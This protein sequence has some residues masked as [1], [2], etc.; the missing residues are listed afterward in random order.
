MKI[1]KIFVLLSTLAIALTSCQV[2]Q[3]IEF[4]V[5]V[6]S[7][8]INIGP[9]GGLRTISVKSP[10]NW[11]A[12]TQAPWI[13][14]S[15]ANGKSS[16]ECRIIIDS[17][18]YDT[19]REAWVTF[20]LLGKTNELKEFQVIQE[21]YP[22]SITLKETEVKIPEYA[23]Y[24]ERSFDVAVNSNVDFDVVIP[25]N[26]S[27]IMSKKENPDFDRGIRPRNVMVHFDWKV[28]T[29]PNKNEVEIVFRPK[30]DKQLARQDNLKV[31]QGAAQEIEAGTVKGDSLAL[32]AIARAINMWREW[33]TAD[34]MALWDGI[35]VWK[36]GKDKG[37][38]K[39]AHFFLFS[40]KEGL[41]F[42]VSY[43]TAAEEL[44]FYGNTNSFLLSLSCGPYICK[45]PQLRKLTIG[46]YGLTELDKNFK[47]LANLEYLDL[48]GNNFEEIPAVLSPENLPNLTALIINANQR[49]VTNDLFNNYK[50]NS[51]GLIN[52]C[53]LR[54][55]GT[56]E[57][58]RR[59]LKW[60]NLDTLRLSVNYLQGTIPDLMDDPDFPKWTA[61]EVNACDTLPAKLIGLPKVLPD[62]DFLAIN[63]N[64]LH[65]ELPDW[66]LYHPKLDLWYPFQL[67]FLQEGKDREGNV[68]G[69][70][71]EPA[72]LN[73]YYEEYKN[74][75]YNPNN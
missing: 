32:L 19:A 70:S 46:A 37:R 51:G 58:P 40:T 6:E 60:N 48:N 56:R 8:V 23:D 54:E 12:T 39:S 18:L 55:D 75:K 43:L 72:N 3:E 71:N 50:E 9:D 47:D 74:K 68:A 14:I 16:T 34:R 59:L 1:N 66:L 44:Y 64:R 26:A 29:R 57:F 67:I 36:E 27:W 35:E 73:Y 7:G 22:Y 25:D 62:T 61:E 65:G 10:S 38:V 17:T 45:L 53:P 20:K 33:D 13:T 11:T 69:F 52:E 4:D 5:A 21:G 28:N 63:L 49:N 31:V 41:P 15:P 24:G 2:S 30:G 42:E